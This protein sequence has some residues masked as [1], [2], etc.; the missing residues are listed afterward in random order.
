[1][2]HDNVREHVQIGKTMPEQDM[3]IPLKHALVDQETDLKQECEAA[4]VSYN[5]A[6]KAQSGHHEVSNVWV[7]QLFQRLLHRWKPGSFA[8]ADDQEDRAHETGTLQ[9]EPPTDT[10]PTEADARKN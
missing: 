6:S 8:P 7:Q 9:G 3:R 5:A 2:P 10:E 1:M 4:G